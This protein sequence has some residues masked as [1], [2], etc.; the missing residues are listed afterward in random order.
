MDYQA[1]NNLIIPRSPPTQKPGEF[2][3]LPKTLTNSP[4]LK[5]KI[6]LRTKLY[7]RKPKSTESITLLYK[8]RHPTPV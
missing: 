5:K 2:V 6:H 8:R 1:V 4:P 3:V 7:Q